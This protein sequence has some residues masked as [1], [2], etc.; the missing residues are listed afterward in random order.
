MK[1]DGEDD[2]IQESEPKDEVD[3]DE[4][5]KTD[6]SDNSDNIL[7][8]HGEEEESE[9]EDEAEK[10]PT[11]EELFGAP[12]S[13]YFGE[14]T[15]EP[16]E[17]SERESR[18][19]PGLFGDT[20]VFGPMKSLSEPTQN[21]PDD[22]YKTKLM[23]AI[24]S[25]KAPQSAETIEKPGVIL[26]RGPL[27]ETSGLEPLPQVI[28]AEEFV[29]SGD[30]KPASIEDQPFTNPAAGNQPEEE[31]MMLSGFGEEPETEK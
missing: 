28:P 20:V 13:R 27:S 6:E 9:D 25:A 23:T 29:G 1:A 17:D 18:A 5:N 24:G 8:L 16:E 3:T 7:T 30:D 4:S 11:V 19:I 14:P 31:Q 12:A 15:E 26:K 22:E 10:K 21:K 2:D